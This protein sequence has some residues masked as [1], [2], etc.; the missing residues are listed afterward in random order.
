MPIVSPSEREQFLERLPTGLRGLCRGETR[1]G[2]LDYRCR[3]SPLMVYQG[4]TD[5]IIPA[6]WDRVDGPPVVPLWE[7][8][9][10]LTAW[11]GG[12]FSDFV[13]IDVEDPEDPVQIAKTPEG[14]LA[15]V[16]F[17]LI[18]DLGGAAQLS[19]R[20]D[21]MVLLQSLATDLG[22]KNLDEILVLERDLST[23]PSWLSRL[24]EFT[25]SVRSS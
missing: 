23:D 8:D 24:L 19:E 2:L 1:N 4:S 17:F 10:D 7:S 3:V 14:L 11:R 20:P 16:F 18:Q 6:A 22:F 9:V 12:L 13:E 5:G 25:T 21:D 15:Y